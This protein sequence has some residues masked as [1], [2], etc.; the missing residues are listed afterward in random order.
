M[1]STERLAADT[2]TREQLGA[3]YDERD[4]LRRQ[5]DAVTR[6][7]ACLDAA[8]HAMKPLLPTLTVVHVTPEMERAATERVR[9]TE[10][11]HER[12]AKWFADHSSPHPAEATVQR[13]TDLY[14]RWVKAGPPRLGTSVS[15]EWDARLVEMRNALLPPT[16]GH[17][18]GCSCHNADELCSGCH[19]CP[20]IC[21]GCDGPKYQPKEV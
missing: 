3:L 6:H 1:S 11:E 5:L 2:I 12:A 13:L 21:H 18:A 7:Y 9:Q 14:E 20:D 10:A 19:R 15:R 16:P 4:A 8:V 17:Q